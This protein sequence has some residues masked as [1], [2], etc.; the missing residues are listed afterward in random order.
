MLFIVV[1]QGS[2][3]LESLNNLVIKKS[4][5]FVFFL[6]ILLYIGLRP[7]NYRFGDM[8]IYNIQFQQ[9]FNGAPLL[10]AKDPLF[11]YFKYGIAKTANAFVFFFL[12]AFFYV[13]PL[14][15]F[16]KKVFKEFWF[17]NFFILVISFSFWTYGTNGIRNGIATSLFLFGLSRDKK[18]IALLILIASTLVHKSML[19]PLFGYIATLFYNNSK[20]YFY[21][22]L[23]CIPLSLV[24]GG[25][26]TNFFMSVGIVEEQALSGY[27]GEFNQ[28][29]EGVE[30]K[31][32]F[33]W[34]FLLYSSFGVLAGWYYVIK[35]NYKDQLYL[36]LLN[37]YLV[38]NAFWV[39]VIRANYSNR[40]AYL[41]WFMLGVIIIYPL[42]KNKFFNNQHQVIVR[43][44]IAYF[45]F[46][47]IMN[48]FIY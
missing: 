15:Y 36:Q 14:Y 20:T 3:K 17:Y 19:L 29:S 48:V 18:S 23:L 33:R 37:I 41:S 12:C 4:L 42:L 9:Y 40:L 16:S 5:G 2:L 21:F 25:F 28:A 43:I 27:L 44:L 11:E 39:L 22:W 13:V 38:C 10:I 30:L 45:A 32:G 6:F 35:M 8:I 46:T 1:A 7:I 47:Y 31:V 26:F 24:M 34:D